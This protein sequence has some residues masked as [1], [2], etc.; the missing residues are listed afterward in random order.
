MSRGLRQN[1]AANVCFS[2]KIICDQKEEFK[3]KISY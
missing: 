2:D 3:K 1:E